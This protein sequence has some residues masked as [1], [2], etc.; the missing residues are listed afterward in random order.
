MN[1]D[2]I[3][4]ISTAPGQGAIAVVRV[5]GQHAI[6]ACNAI[7]KAKNNIRD[8]LSQKG[9][10]VSFGNIINQKGETVDEV[11][12][13]VFRNPHSYTGEDSVEISC[14]GSAFIQQQILQLLIAN[15]CRMAEPGEY[16]QR[17][18]MNGKMDLSQAEA[19]ADLI[20]AESAA[21][22]KLAI[23]QLKGG[24]SEELNRLRAELLD[25]TSLIELELDFSEEEVEFANRDQLNT[26]INHIELVTT[27]LINS[28]SVGNAV[29]NGIPVAIVGETNVGKSTLL[30]RL[31]N[32]ERAIVSDI[33]GTTR[34]TIE[35]VMTFGGVQ[36][37]FIDTAG[38]RD[39]RDKIESLGIERTFHKIDQATIVLPVLD[40]TRSITELTQFAT[41]IVE[42]TNG[43]QRIFIVNKIDS[44]TEDKRAALHALPVLMNEPCCFL[45][46]KFGQGYDQLQQAL[47]TAANIPEIGA[48]DVI[49]T[50]AR[51]YEALLKA[52]EAILRVIE[53]L[54][55]NI[56][57]EFVSQ[58]IREA[59]YYLGLITGGSITNDEIL[60]NIFQKFCIGK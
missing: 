60:G 19:V 59:I 14:H 12:L 49:V 45:S 32:E 56:S 15:G 40:S 6:A 25:F 7:F 39:T 8:V 17:A 28:F 1:N 5:S 26:L 10:T 54:N 3:C 41:D 22:H 35:E 52:Q 57:G 58:D 13:T 27:K 33:H 51:H 36:F 44:L 50:N 46:A 53:G 30:N 24:F 37:R 47:I 20:A 43:K 21:A 16:T 31:L 18:F 29:K 23:N 48:S 42:K 4:A 55:N 38:I 34:D 9:Q 2:T 11:L